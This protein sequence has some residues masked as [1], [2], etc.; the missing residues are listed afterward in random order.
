MIS[1]F[2][3]QR[4]WVHQLPTGFKLL[5]LALCSV[6]LMLQAS[7]EWNAVALA[8]GCAIYTSIGAAGIRRLRGLIASLWF[9]LLMLGVAQVVAL[10]V[11]GLAWEA[12]LIA[13]LR[14][15]LQIAALVVLADVVT[16]TTRMQDMLDALS[17][18]FGPLRFVGLR[19]TSIGTAVALMIRSVGLLSRDWQQTRLA[20]QARGAKRPGLRLIAPVMSRMIRRT[21]SLSQAL[22]ART[23][24]CAQPPE[25]ELHWPGHRPK[26]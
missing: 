22:A 13:S 21:E 19:P 17:P 16:A 23:L 3:A 1:L 7:L 8:L 4:S 2:I 20:F 9:L 14:T 12:A 15:L 24:S 25:E 26:Q 18:L 10:V 5:A 6:G 11:Q